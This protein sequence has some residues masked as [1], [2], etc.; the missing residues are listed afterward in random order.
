MYV[1]LM[2]LKLSCLIKYGPIAQSSTVDP[3]GLRG[4]ISLD[5][6]VPIYKNN[7][8][9]SAIQTSAVDVIILYKMLLIYD[10]N[11]LGALYLI[12]NLV[13]FDIII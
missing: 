7:L 4:W 12:G 11:F 10:S 3:S 13:L 9:I 8:Q 2:T 5:S 6:R 1:P